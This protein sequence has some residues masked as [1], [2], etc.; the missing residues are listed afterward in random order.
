M[1]NNFENYKNIVNLNMEYELA[2]S[3]KCEHHAH[4]F[5]GP[6]RNNITDIIKQYLDDNS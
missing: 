4:H 1:N 3:N 2:L 6:Y 5:Y